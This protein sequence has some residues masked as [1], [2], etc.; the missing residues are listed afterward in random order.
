[1]A[2][3]YYLLKGW[4]ALEFLLGMQ[5]SVGAQSS[6]V[7][8]LLSPMGGWGVAQVRAVSWAPPRSL[9]GMMAVPQPRSCSSDVGAGPWGLLPGSQKGGK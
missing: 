1:M 8:L 9:P 7:V 2:S 3:A 4:R 6:T 5:L